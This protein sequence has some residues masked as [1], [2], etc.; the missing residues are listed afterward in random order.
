METRCDVSLAIEACGDYGLKRKD[1][2][3]IVGEVREA[4]N[5]WRDEAEALGIPRWEQEGMAEAFEQ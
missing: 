1:A 3:R 2:A 4:A 5:H